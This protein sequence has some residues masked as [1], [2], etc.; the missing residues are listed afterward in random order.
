MARRLKV[1]MSAFAC[2]PR[3]GSEPA[4]GWNWMR[5]MARHHDLW[6]ITWSD[7]RAA[8]E[9]DPFVR[10]HPNV[11]WIYYEL[12]PSVPFWQRSR[13]DSQYYYLCWQ[14][15]IGLLA[16]RLQREVRFDL[17]H[18]VTWV[19]YWTP[20]FLALLVP[21]LIFGPVGGG[22]TA[23]R[24]FYSTFGRRG[25]FFERVRDLVTLDSG[26]ALCPRDRPP[27]GPSFAPL[28]HACRFQAAVRA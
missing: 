25:S 6:V 12:P 27:G 22:E 4:V 11:R 17:M 15:G 24:P 13:R 1:L 9:S 10:D 23:P 3:K 26:K 7:Y 5:Q 16:R 28:P 19:R 18:H 20:S 14:A 21:P 2:E 8:I